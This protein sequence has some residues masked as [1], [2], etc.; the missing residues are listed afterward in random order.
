MITPNKF[1]SLDKSIIGK[2][3][4]LLLEGV[5]KITVSELKKLTARK[6]VDV[7]EFLLG[8]DTLFILGRIELDEK[9]GV[10]KYVS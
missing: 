3:D 5:E 8:L 7:G 6:F 4:C 9:N 1:T 10:I 2:V